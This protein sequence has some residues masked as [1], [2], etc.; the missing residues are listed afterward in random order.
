MTADKVTVANLRPA[1]SLAHILRGSSPIPSRRSLWWNLRRWVRRRRPGEEPLTGITAVSHV[2]VVDLCDSTHVELVAHALQSIE[3]R[4][5]VHA[6]ASSTTV[7]RSRDDVPCS[8]RME[9][10]RSLHRW[11]HSTCTT[12]QL[13]ALQLVALRA[14]LPGGAPIFAAAETHRA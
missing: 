1:A 2:L 5:G 7:G 4:T 14:G 12:A 6:S 11:R 3:R 8:R 10:P 13:P 9:R